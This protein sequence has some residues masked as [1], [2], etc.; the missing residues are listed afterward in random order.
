L[1]QK[2]KG[3]FSFLTAASVIHISKVSIF[4]LW[5]PEIITKNTVFMLIVHN[6]DSWLCTLLYTLIIISKL[7]VINFDI[8]VILGNLSR[9]FKLH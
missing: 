5:K 3:R 6:H 1:V 7:F 8:L 4:L 9:K 2:K